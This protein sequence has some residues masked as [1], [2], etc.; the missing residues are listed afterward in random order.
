[1]IKVVPENRIRRFSGVMEAR[2]GMGYNAS[3][4][5]QQRTGSAPTACLPLLGYLSR[6]G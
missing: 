5:L 4:P 2:I 1:M 6:P 3:V